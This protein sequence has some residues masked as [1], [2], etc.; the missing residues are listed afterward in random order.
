MTTKFV[1][2]FISQH[3]LTGSTGV[4]WVDGVR[5]DNKILSP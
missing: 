5:V 2:R 4:S 1:V 3:E